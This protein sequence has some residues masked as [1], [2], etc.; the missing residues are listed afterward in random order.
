MKKRIN[1]LLL[2]F[3]SLLFLAGCGE[4]APP[5][6][7]DPATA[8]EIAAVSRGA[9]SAEN[10]ASGQV[11]S[12]K[13]ES[14]SVALSAHCTDVAVEVGDVVSAGQT[15]CTLD[16]S[17]TQ[18]NYDTAALSYANAQKSYNEQS[19]L[20]RQQV[21]Q[22]EKNLSDTKELFALGAASQA[23]IDS[24]QLALDNARATMSSTLDQLTLSMQNYK[25]TMTQLA[26]TLANIGSGGKVTAP[27][28][29]VIL[30]LSA[31]E[32]GFVSPS[33]PVAT[34]ASLSEME[35]Q[36]GVSE[37]LVNK[38]QVGSQVS[39]TVDAA[40]ATFQ[41]T[42]HDLDRTPN[43][44]THLYGV[45]VR[46]PASAAKGLMAGMF[47]NVTFYTDTQSDVVIIPT[48]AIQTGM[49]SQYVYILD[50]DN[51]AHRVPVETGLVGD[52]VTEITAGQS[53]GETLVTVGQFYLS[54]GAPVR[55]VTSE[56]TP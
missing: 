21:A 39:V 16:I 48:E 50:Q 40:Q 49:D 9:I 47:A 26:S 43:A 30:S 44:N 8:V 33:A 32:N 36:V 5:E 38:L 27:I 41:S 25:A 34:I 10:S 18:A 7:D 54:E 53:G 52:G 11:V 20:L 29:G 4:E 2:T 15:L 35:V 3:A 28:S 19:A 13:Q 14:V 6:P 46:I 56:V 42:I 12:G 1:S 31:T 51:I 22:A 55:V 37:A 23:E 24:A 45:T 17:A